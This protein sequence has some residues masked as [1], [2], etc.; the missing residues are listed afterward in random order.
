RRLDAQRVE[1]RR[2][3]INRVAVLRAYLT[4]GLDPLRPNNHERIGDSAPVG[5]TLPAPERSVASV[6]PAP[7]V[8]VE[9]LGAAQVVNRSKILLQVV[10]HVVEELAFIHRAVRAALS[11]RAVV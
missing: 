1:H 6:C 3:H 11:T 5:F 7:G 4:L 8:V 2:Y 9:V 10:G